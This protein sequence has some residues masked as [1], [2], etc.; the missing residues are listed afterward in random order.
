[1]LTNRIHLVVKKSKF[2]L[3]ATVHDLVM[4]SFLAD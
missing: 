3:R 2:E 1:M 4:E